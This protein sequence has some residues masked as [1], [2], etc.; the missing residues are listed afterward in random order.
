M[1]VSPL[2]KHRLAN[3]TFLKILGLTTVGWLAFF[4]APGPLISRTPDESNRTGFIDARAV[5]LF[6][7]AQPN[8]PTAAIN[9]ANISTRLAVG[10]GDNVLIAGFII[11]G[12]Q[13]KKVVLRGLGP[14][15]PV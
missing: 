8:G 7:T 13:P 14:L 10:S 5:K 9:L 3:R 1:V 2:L 15:L 6:A 11:T 12:S 4:A